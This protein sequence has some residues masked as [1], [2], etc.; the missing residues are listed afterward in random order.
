[1]FGSKKKRKTESDDS[2]WGAE[3]SAPPSSSGGN[4]DDEF[5]GGG[6]GSAPAQ[7]ATQASSPTPQPKPRPTD[8]PTN[9]P[10]LLEPI[11]LFVC[12]L[13]RVEQ[14][15]PRSLTYSQV[16]S[17]TKD[18]I[19]ECKDLIRQNPS[20]Q[21]QFE[22]VEEPLLWLLDYWFGSSEEFSSIREEWNRNRMGELPDNEEEGNLAGD[23]VF[24]YR[25]DKTLEEPITDE[26]ANERLA[27]YYIALGLGFTGI[28]F[29]NIPEHHQE[30]RSRMEKMYPRVR[31]YVDAS[32]ASRITPECYNN[33][34]KRDFIAPARD[35]P[36]ILLASFLCLLG[37][38]FVGYFYLYGQRKSD[39]EKMIKTVNDTRLLAPASQ[40]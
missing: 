38:L 5:W 37:T 13:H 2:P 32:L 9:L 8:A 39:L 35:R 34:D 33:I 23:E 25:L 27:F 40:N 19:K 10:A 6:N 31:K 24:I 18:L 16:R 26:L 28:F 3:P 20:L 30:L 17:E 29:K 4:S 15:C 11:F 12:R 7:P 21:Q 36:I 1:M 14:G 22:K